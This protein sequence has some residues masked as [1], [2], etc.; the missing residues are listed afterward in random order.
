[1]SSQVDGSEGEY[2]AGDGEGSGEDASREVGKEE[3]ERLAKSWQ[4][5]E[6]TDTS[7]EEVMAG[8][9]GRLCGERP[10]FLV[11]CR[12]LGIQWVMFLWTGMMTCLILGMT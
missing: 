5:A 11:L 2:S 10:V 8:T 12:R 6:E 7:D 4:E 3:E 1:M 9:G